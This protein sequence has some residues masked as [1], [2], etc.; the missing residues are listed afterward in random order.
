MGQA[1]LMSLVKRLRLLPGDP[2]HLLDDGYDWTSLK[3]VDDHDV[4][5]TLGVFTVPVL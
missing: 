1:I 2:I 3:A 5:H 4:P